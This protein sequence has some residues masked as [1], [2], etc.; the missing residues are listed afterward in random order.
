MPSLHPTALAVEQAL[1][2]IAETGGWRS[3]QGPKLDAF[4]SQLGDMFSRSFVRLCCSGTFGIELALRSLRLDKDAE[5]L[6][7]GYDYPGNFRAIQDAGA[8]VALCDVAAGRWIP[9]VEQLEEAV[10]PMT[11][12]IVV[13]HLH[14]TLAPMEKICEWANRHG[15]WVIEDACQEP[16]AVLSYSE[17]ATGQRRAGSCGNI[18]VFSFGGSKLMSAGR[19]G[20]VLTSDP[21]LAQRMT[22]FCERGNDSFALSE[23]QAT[24]LNPQL[25]RLQVD[26]KL[27]REAATALHLGIRKFDWLGMEGM[28]ACELPAFYKVGFRIQPLILQSA[29]VQHYVRKFAAGQSSELSMAREFVLQFCE[30]RGLHIGLGFRNIAN[31]SNRRCRFGGPLNNSRDASEST[32]VLHHDHLLDPQT[33]ERSIDR[34]VEI[35][36]QVHLEIGR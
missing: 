4:R 8:G 15:I 27:R 3:Y 13:S 25:Q 5:V 14:G 19:G 11:R 26:N 17:E 30:S 21:S 1:V 29:R 24:V 18:S 20:A 34:V 9:E 32:L 16:G 31:R 33:G 22:V 35:L 6:M 2:E 36:E 23:L 7:A 12:A 28:A 10:S